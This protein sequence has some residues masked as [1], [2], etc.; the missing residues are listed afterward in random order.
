MTNGTIIKIK[1]SLMPLH[2]V[3]NNF[4]ITIHNYIIVLKFLLIII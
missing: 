4:T 2:F 3:F 1:T